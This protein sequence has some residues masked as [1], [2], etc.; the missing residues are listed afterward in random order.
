MRVAAIFEYNTEP[1]TTSR[2]GW[3]LIQK[4]SNLCDGYW[5]ITVADL[6]RRSPESAV[7]MLANDCKVDA[8]VVYGSIRFIIPY[9]KPLRCAKLAVITDSCY[10][11]PV[12]ETMD[13]YV[14][15]GFDLILQRGTYDPDADYTTPQ[16]WWPFSADPEE[17]HP[18]GSGQ[19]INK[20]GFAGSLDNGVYSQRRRAVDTLSSD[21]VLSPCLYC[22]KGSDSGAIY[23]EFLRT[24]VAGLTSTQM[25][26]IS[27]EYA[28][29][30]IPMD[31]PS[32]PR[33]KT[34]EMMASATAVL[35]PPFFMQENL[36]PCNTEVCFQYK[37]DCSDIV[38]VARAIINDTDRTREMALAGYD[39]FMHYHTD[40]IRVRE[41]YDYIACLV[42]GKP[43]ERT[44]GI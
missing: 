26:G 8:I 29:A 23:P 35:T 25:E 39:H 12:K 38:P 31:M 14:E 20:I 28:G 30:P 2:H 32:T 4:L 9:I 11:F 17:F 21:G 36:F 13:R 43:L 6:L 16:T 33:A 41:L 24:H 34:F 37:Y 40:E 19:R 27:P 42:E 44:W 18:N 22:H 10:M 5:Q 3:R 7:S 1:K 15:C